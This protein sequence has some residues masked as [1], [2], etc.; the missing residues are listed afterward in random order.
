MC[1]CEAIARSAVVFEFLRGRSALIVSRRRRSCT[2]PSWFSLPFRF[3]RR[4]QDIGKGGGG[5][6]SAYK[7]SQ[8]GII[9]LYLL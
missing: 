7:M 4:I 1:G 6:V 2:H 8:A 3:Q 9:S 5:C